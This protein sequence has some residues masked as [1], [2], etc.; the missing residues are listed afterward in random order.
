[1]AGRTVALDLPEELVEL[2]GSAEAAASRA[3]E[4]LV[5]EL[6]RDGRIGQSRV[7]ELLGLTRWDVLDLMAEH[8]VKQGP[9]TQDELEQDAARA[10]RAAL[11]DSHRSLILRQD[12]E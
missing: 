5:F 2:F 12:F 4:A 10:V 6:L 11:F 3:K 7:T 8:G 9:R 1:M